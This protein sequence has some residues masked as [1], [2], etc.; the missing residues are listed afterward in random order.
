MIST[1]S[2]AL[3]TQVAT[4]HGQIG[5]RGGGGSTIGAATTIGIGGGGAGSG[6]VSGAPQRQQSAV[7]T[8]GLSSPQFGQASEA[9]VE[10]P[11]VPGRR[12]SAS[13]VDVSPD[14]P[15]A[16]AQ[17]NGKSHV[18]QNHAAWGRRSL[19]CHTVPQLGQMTRLTPGS[20][21]RPIGADL[22]GSTVGSGSVVVS[23]P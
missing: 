13:S 8:G 12:A 18:A 23:W 16:R 14:W 11:P 15:P 3:S 17:N 19:P 1:M 2:A 7:G 22:V 20:T 10:R 21:A 6:V 4:T 9:S 5:R